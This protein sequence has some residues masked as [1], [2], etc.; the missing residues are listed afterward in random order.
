MFIHFRCN[1]F[2]LIFLHLPASLLK[3]R[4]KKERGFFPISFCF[5]RF[6]SCKSVNG[7]IRMIFERLSENHCECVVLS[8]HCVKVCFCIIFINADLS[9]FSTTSSRIE[10]Y[11][12]ILLSAS[13]HRNT[14]MSSN[15]IKDTFTNNVMAFS[16]HQIHS[17]QKSANDRIIDLK[18]KPAMIS[19]STSPPTT[20]Y[21]VCKHQRVFTQHQQQWRRR[22]RW[23]CDMPIMCTSGF[24]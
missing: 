20:C 17:K 21:N 8:P 6:F 15:T 22:R 10:W 16:L 14:T 13:L 24:E 1:R 3:S 23:E 5:V 19:L 2:K 11:N 12:S 9:R 4:E 7:V 18:K